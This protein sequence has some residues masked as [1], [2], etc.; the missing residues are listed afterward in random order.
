MRA[1]DPARGPSEIEAHMARAH[2]ENPSGEGG[3]APDRIDVAVSGDLAVEQGSY[4]GP[5][6]EGR[7]ITVHKKLNDEWKILA[8]MSVSTTPG[9]GAPAWAMESLE[10]WYEAFN[11]RD[12]EAIADLY[13]ADARVGDAQGRAAIIADFEAEWAEADL[14]CYGG[15]DAFHL[16]GTLAAGWGRDFC[17][18]GATGEHAG[19]SRWVAVHELQADGSW[20]MIRDRGEPVE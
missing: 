2:L 19:A 6:D 10:Q 1:R 8:D 16:V 18:D 5:G 14:E 12:A 17:T 20:L 9:G 15:Y 3:F 4:Q 13:T 11:A 7:Y